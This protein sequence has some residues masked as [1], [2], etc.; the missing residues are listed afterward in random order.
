MRSVCRVRNTPSLRMH[1]RTRG[2]NLLIGAQKPFK[3]AEHTPT[4]QPGYLRICRRSK[5][6]FQQLPLSSEIYA[7]LGDR[8]RDLHPQITVYIGPCQSFC[9]YLRGFNLVPL[10]RIERPLSKNRKVRGTDRPSIPASDP[11]SP[12][13]ERV[14]AER[15][16]QRF[17]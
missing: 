3:A 13:S 11:L 10:G 8:R 4:G 14:V 1:K 12:L 5:R 15:M 2:K 7:V 17:F 16:S 9:L 6:L